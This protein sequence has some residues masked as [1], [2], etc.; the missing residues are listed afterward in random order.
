M[1]AYILPIINSCTPQIF[2][3]LVLPDIAPCDADGIVQ[4]VCTSISAALLLP[5]YV[6]VQIY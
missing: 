3:G 6:Y 2:P 1:F 4:L 5:L